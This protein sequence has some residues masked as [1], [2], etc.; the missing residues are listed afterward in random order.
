MLL[1]G[2]GASGNRVPARAAAP[3]RMTLLVDPR[4]PGGTSTAVAAEIRALAG[5]VEL[6]IVDLSTGMFSGREDN[7]RLIGALEDMGLP[8]RRNDPVVRGDTI[9]LHNPACLKFDAKLAMRISCRTLI[10]VAHENFLRPDGG[11]G[12]DAASCLE[13][14]DAAAVCG[15]RLVAPISAPNRRGVEG[16]L[17]GRSLDWQ[18]TPFDWPSICDLPQVPPTSLPRDRRGRHSRPGLE[19]FP[20]WHRM[21]VQFPAHA[22]RCLILGGDILLDEP[23]GLPQHWEVRRF[24]EM[25]VARFLEQIDFL[26]YYTNPHWQES[27]GRAIAEAIGAGKVVITDAATAEPFGSAVVQAEDEEIDGIIAG[28]VAAP[29]RFRMFVS[30]AQDWLAT[31]GPERF[32]SIVLPGITMIGSG[33]N[34][35]L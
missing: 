6:E 17:G 27:F 1:S 3:L 5:H 24:G 16:W 9:V 13:V 31:H 22:E 8:L 25:P 14:I 21:L 23:E 33:N 11:E 34:A 35:V 30:Q 2:N 20:E 26:V 29:E 4:F 7:P 10:V 15:H 12:F 18:V 28:F 32:R 19:K